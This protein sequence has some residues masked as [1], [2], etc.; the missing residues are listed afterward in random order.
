[1]QGLT[2]GVN[3]EAFVSG[4]V[5]HGAW[6]NDLGSVMGRSYGCPAFQSNVAAEVL[7]KIKGGSLY[8]SYTPICK[9]LHQK[10]LEQ[11]NGWKS[12]CD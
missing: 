6:Y 5:M 2:P 1:M 10:V 11:I 4:V 3:D 12:F 9:E 7:N 8:Y